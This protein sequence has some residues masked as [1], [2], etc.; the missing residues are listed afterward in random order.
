MAPL[1]MALLTMALPTM[2]GFVWVPA[3]WRAA[4]PDGAPTRGHFA[5]HAG[6]RAN[7]A[8]EPFEHLVRANVS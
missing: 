1:T 4:P 6:W 7:C 2:A 8:L 3:A 5:N